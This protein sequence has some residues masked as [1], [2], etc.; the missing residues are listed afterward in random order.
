MVAERQPKVEMRTAAE[1][2]REPA[3]PNRAPA[4]ASPMRLVSPIV[5]TGRARR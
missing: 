1:S 4:A 2:H 3:A 5:S